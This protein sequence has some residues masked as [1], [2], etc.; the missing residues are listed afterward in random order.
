MD[1]FTSLL[2]VKILHIHY[3]PRHSFS[4][5]DHEYDDTWVIGIGFF[6]DISNAQKQRQ[7]KMPKPYS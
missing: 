4:P 6:C 1:F 5:S 7:P 3:T 2:V